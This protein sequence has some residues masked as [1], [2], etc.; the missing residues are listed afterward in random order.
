[1]RDDRANI[2]SESIA[3]SVA[4]EPRER[5]KQEEALFDCVASMQSCV[6][7]TFFAARLIG[8]LALPS[9]FTPADDDDLRFS[10]PDVVTFINTNWPT[11]DAFRLKKEGRESFLTEPFRGAGRVGNFSILV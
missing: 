6:E 3:R 8:A 7:S 1:L 10:L 9:G 5:L 11:N 4:P 2:F